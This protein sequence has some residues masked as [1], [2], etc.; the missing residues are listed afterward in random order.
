MTVLV[1]RLELFRFIRIYRFCWWAIFNLNAGEISPV[2][3]G[4]T[5]PD[6]DA[7]PHWLG[8]EVMLCNPGARVRFGIV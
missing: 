2:G 8:I 5:T 1:L 3:K 6:L 7:I 4:F